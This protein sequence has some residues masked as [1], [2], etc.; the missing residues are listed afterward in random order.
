M[1]KLLFLLPLLCAFAL[2]K[3]QCIKNISTNPDNPLNEEFLPLI[4]D[5]FPNNGPHTN[6]SFLNT[7]DWRWPNNIEVDL[8][9][10]WSHPLNNFSGIYNMNNPFSIN[11]GSDFAYLQQPENPELRD[12]HWEDGWELLW[13]NLGYFPNGDPINAPSN[14]TYFGN[15]GIESEPTPA[16]I[17][18]FVLYNRY[19]GL[20]RLFANVWFD[21]LNA[22]F[23]DI[24]VTLQY[25]ANSDESK[26]LSGILRHASGLDRTLDQATAI[27]SVN[28]PRLH[29]PNTSS[30]FVAEFQLG[31]D[32]CACLSE[33]KFELVFE[34]LETMNVDILSRSIAIN[35]AI[36]DNNYRTEDFLNLSDYS[37][38]N[39]E[40]GN[41]IYK[42]MDDLLTVYNQ[43]L[44]K[45]N[46]DLQDYKAYENNLGIAFVNA[47]K[48]S[49]ANGISGGIP[50]G[51]VA[52]FLSVL[53]GSLGFTKPDK[54]FSTSA[55]LPIPGYPLVL[56]NGDQS[57]DGSSITDVRI[58]DGVAHWRTYKYNSLEKSLE[59][60]GK[61]YLAQGV[62]FL[63]AALLGK[64]PE[65]PV[66]PSPS[67]ATLTETV[68]RGTIEKANATTT[69]SLFIPGTIPNGYPNK[70][71]IT[72][73]SFPAYNETPGI[74]ALLRT[75]SLYWEEN[76]SQTNT[77]LN[78]EVNYASPED[79]EEGCASDSLYFFREQEYRNVHFK[80][81]DPLEYA[82]NPTI[83]LNL[84]KTEIFVQYEIE[85]RREGTQ[86]VTER[87]AIERS[88][89][90]ELHRLEEGS[91]KHLHVY[92]SKWTPIEKAGEML[93]S[94]HNIFSTDY[95]KRKSIASRGTVADHTMP[96]GRPWNNLFD[97]V[98]DN[99]TS[100]IVRV[101]LKIMVDAYFDQTGSYGDPVN[102]TQTFTHLLYGSEEGVDYLSSHGAPMAQNPIQNVDYNVGQ[103]VLGSQTITTSSPFVSDVLNNDIFVNAEEILV[104]GLLYAQPGYT[105]HLSAPFGVKLVPGGRFSL[106]SQFITKTL[107]FYNFP[108]IAPASQEDIDGFCSNQENGYL[109]NNKVLAK[110][111]TSVNKVIPL[112]Q[113]IEPLSLDL[114]P[115]PISQQASVRLSGLKEGSVFI[116]VSDQQGSVFYQSSS[117]SSSGFL[118]FQLD[119]SEF[120][121]GI[122]ILYIQAN[123]G[124]VVSRKVVKI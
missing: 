124:E 91:N 38:G 25:T 84:E 105:I 51:D 2:A 36:T 85:I 123:N 88:N 20:M 63:S 14:G 40:P 83:D 8:G 79:E 30:W 73:H 5:W 43:Q 7:F 23:Q 118:Q 42:E 99:F 24:V 90:V 37:T 72:A 110:R 32:P 122:Y 57:D 116:T 78:V 108:T 54:E 28:S 58:N 60:D 39:Y 115:N 4:N 47:V 95:L 103:L 13:M 50:Y 119:M 71:E 27:T 66:K 114:F 74:F 89:V 17:P 26:N 53:G 104:T 111:S 15:N 121:P 18:Y 35:Q 44:V 76:Y 69:G 62:D 61:K 113:Q 87:T 59:K 48:G 106:G 117:K 82:F 12:F 52:A 93:Y 49:V 96:C 102:T 94:M 56:Q 22:S 70:T 29:P 65:M 21:N 98:E 81:K 67:V 100:E 10:P 41:R 55:V 112:N 109:A 80:L 11:M 86:P 19:S 64:K 31:Y 107:N 45:Y 16:N 92:N 68:Y 3:A 97:K 120:A 75:P 46:Q 33:G 9:M 6:N 1:K 34:T 101:K 77:L